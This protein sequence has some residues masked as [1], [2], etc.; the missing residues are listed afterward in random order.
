VEV[1]AANPA[2]MQT[3]SKAQAA[4]AWSAAYQPPQFGRKRCAELSATGPASGLG[5]AGG[6]GRPAGLGGGLGFVPA[7]DDATSYATSYNTS[8]HQRR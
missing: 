3:S 4:A 7:A 8:Y 1:A 5:L 6:Q 2:L